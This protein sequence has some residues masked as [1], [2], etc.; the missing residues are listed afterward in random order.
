MGNVD[1]E[2]IDV[3][4]MSDPELDKFMKD[5]AISLKISEARKIVELIGRNPT[6][7]ELHIFNIEW[8]EH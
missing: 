4:D 5:N 1:V 3:T 2:L 7:T 6:L 8:S